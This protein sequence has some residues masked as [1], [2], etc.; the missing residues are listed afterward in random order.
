MPDGITELSFGIQLSTED[1]T[2]IM[3]LHNA[4]YPEYQMAEL[5]ADDGKNLVVDVTGCG[6]KQKRPLYS[7][8]GFHSNHKLRIINRGDAQRHFKIPK[9]NP[10]K[11]SK[12]NRKKKLI[13]NFKKLKNSK[14]NRW[15][16]LFVGFFLCLIADRE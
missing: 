12:N 3:T 10:E 15:K 13:K 2:K 14:K 16:I 7:Y 6:T 5:S 1:P 11:N 8:F 9:Q 4:D